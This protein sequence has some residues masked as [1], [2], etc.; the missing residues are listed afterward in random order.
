MVGSSSCGHKKHHITTD[1]A[2]SKA[3]KVTFRPFNVPLSESRRL[4][5][6]FWRV[7]LQAATPDAPLVTLRANTI[8]SDAEADSI[9]RLR[10]NRFRNVLPGL[11]GGQGRHSNS[12]QVELPQSG[13]EDVEL[14]QHAAAASKLR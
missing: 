11:G 12:R 8:G 1:M 14:A 7:W 6:R 5:N 3:L 9:F 13:L 2:V 10:R 4:G